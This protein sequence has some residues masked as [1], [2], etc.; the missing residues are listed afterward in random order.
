VIEENERREVR[1]VGIEKKGKEKNRDSTLMKLYS[2]IVVKHNRLIKSPVEM[3]VS[4]FINQN[5]SVRLAHQS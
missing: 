4:T 1:R 2:G 5:A 3:C